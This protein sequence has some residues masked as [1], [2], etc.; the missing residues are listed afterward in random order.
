MGSDHFI[1]VEA[2]VINFYG[3]I[4]NV[5]KDDVLEELKQ[6]Q[7]EVKAEKEKNK[8]VER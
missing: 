4:N 1:K 2:H 5:L 7:A 8:D 6:A 3:V